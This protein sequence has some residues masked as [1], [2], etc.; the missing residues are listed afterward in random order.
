[1]AGFLRHGR[2]ATGI[3]HGDTIAPGRRER[4]QTSLARGKFLSSFFLPLFRETLAVWGTLGVCDVGPP[5]AWGLGGRQ[6]TTRASE[7][8]G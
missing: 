3:G 6:V 1:M 5:L 7:R 2:R 4:A 8:C